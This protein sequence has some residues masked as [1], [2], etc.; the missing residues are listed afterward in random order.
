ME[1]ADRRAQAEGVLALARRR[2]VE[3]PGRTESEIKEWFRF[4]DFDHFVEVYGLFAAET[5]L[6]P[7]IWSE[8]PNYKRHIHPARR[9]E[10]ETLWNWHESRTAA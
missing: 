10:L 7:L 8:F 3:L 5:T 2:G 4:R 6:G 1:D 9:I